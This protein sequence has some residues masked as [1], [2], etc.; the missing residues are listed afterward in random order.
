VKA[1][2][3]DE[4]DQL[5]LR[6]PDG[7]RAALEQVLAEVQPRV[8]RICGRMLLFP[9]DAEE[10]TQDALLL[11]ATKID[12]FE[13]R[14]RFTTWLHAVASNSARSTYRS[15]K[16]RAAERV[17]DQLP[18]HAD[19]RTT[20]VIAGSRL[21][22]LEALEV[23]GTDHPELVEP[24]VLRDVQEL[25]YNEIAALLDVPLGTVKSRIHS[26]RNAVRPLLEV[27]D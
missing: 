11:V 14:S 10:A 25:D 3:A 6:A 2:E 15:L 12:Q 17:T 22:L 21:D 13:G 27:S 19:P 18:V 20:S 5:A 1:V 4:L 8:R 24:L 7:D 16:R 23:V 26:A 9:E